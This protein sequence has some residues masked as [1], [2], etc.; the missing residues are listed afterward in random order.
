[1][2]ALTSVLSQIMLPLPSGVPMTLQP[3]AVAL[4]GFTLGSKKGTAAV[5]VYLA[6]G[7]VGVPVFTGMMGGLGKIFGVTG[8]FL[9][10]FLALSFFCGLGEK[11]RNKAAVA[12]FCAAGLIIC[13]LMGTAYYA[14]L[15]KTGLVTAFL[16]VSM[17]YILKDAL[18]IMGAWAV[19]KAVHRA[20]GAL[21]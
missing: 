12:I 4:T 7:A 10:G 20:L 5:G 13:H 16:A 6:L 17:P 19:S 3:F 15:S 18:L 14:F 21:G 9:F 2:A 8:G 1:M 11:C